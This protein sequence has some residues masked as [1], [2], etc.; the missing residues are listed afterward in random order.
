MKVSQSP[1][2]CG[3]VVQHGSRPRRGDA[4][5]GR[6]RDRAV[7]GLGTAPA[8]RPGPGRGRRRVP[9]SVVDLRERIE[10]ADALLVVTPEYNGSIPGVL[11]N[12]IDWASARHRGSSLRT[13]P[14]RS[15]ARPPDSTA[16]SGPSRICA[17]CS[18]SAVRG[19]S[20]A[21]CRS[22]VRTRYSTSRDSSQTRRRGA[23]ARACGGARRGGAPLAVAA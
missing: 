15:P 17:R 16:R 2:A 4:R 20:P 18:A 21:S 23:P 13:R 12:A 11:K 10:G 7:R 9:A 14:S 3:G 5:S 8:L 1:E 6:R 19:S 22:R